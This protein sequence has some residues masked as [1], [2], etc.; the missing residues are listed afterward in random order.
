MLPCVPSVELLYLIFSIWR[1][2]VHHVSNME[3]WKF[4][5]ELLL[6]KC[7]VNSEALSMSQKLGMVP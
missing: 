1:R 6:G 5:H 3:S 2:N 4:A 7:F